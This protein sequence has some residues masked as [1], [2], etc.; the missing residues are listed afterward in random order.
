MSAQI[1]QQA[2]AQLPTMLNRYGGPVGVV[3]RLVG[4]GTDEVEAGVP[5]WGWLGVG[6]VAGGIVVYAVRDK[7]K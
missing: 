6:V 2:V 5:W 7:I 3:G 1:A 4:L